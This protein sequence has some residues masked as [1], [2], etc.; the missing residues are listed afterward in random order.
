MLNNRLDVIDD[1]TTLSLNPQSTHSS[2]H[3]QTEIRIPRMP[4]R[5]SNREIKTPCHLKDYVLSLP[6]LKT[7]TI[8]VSNTIHNNNQNNLSFNALFNKL[9][10]IIPDVIAS[11]SQALV[12][13][14]CCD[15]E[16][17]SYEKAPLSRAWQKAMEQQ[18]DALHANKT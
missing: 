7:S 8:S 12:E 9:H 17:C 18:F 6:N 3:T 15:S 5:K 13:S 10:Y 4:Q 14:I 1:H 11:K 2:P 16:A